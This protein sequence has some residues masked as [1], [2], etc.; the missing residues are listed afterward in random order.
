M[1]TRKRTYPNSTGVKTKRG[2]FRR[3]YD[4][5]TRPKKPEKL[6]RDR[7]C[8]PPLKCRRIKPKNERTSTSVKLRFLEV[9]GVAVEKNPKFALHEKWSQYFNCELKYH[10]HSRKAIKMRT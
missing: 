4:P 3:C 9:L 2:D 6:P 8:D 1:R 7:G 10:E 5:L